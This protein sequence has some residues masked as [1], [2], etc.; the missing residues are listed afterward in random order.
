MSHDTDL[1]LGV[2]IS[3]ADGSLLLAT[4]GW[5][6]S[7]F[8]DLENASWLVT[9]YVLTLCAVQPLVSDTGLFVTY[10]DG[11]ALICSEFIVRQA[12]RYIW[13]QENDID[14]L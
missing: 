7:E 6:A 11:G 12:Q 2:F 5:I 4:N 14:R 1:T 8:N 10:M 13:P 9:S 3:N